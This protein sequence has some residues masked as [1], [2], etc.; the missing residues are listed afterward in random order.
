[1]VFSLL[2]RVVDHEAT[3]GCVAR[4]RMLIGNDA[5]RKVSRDP[6]AGSDPKKTEGLL[7][8]TTFLSRMLISNNSLARIRSLSFLYP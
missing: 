2:Y 1:M 3:E 6:G 4:R 7:M 8:Y 5:I